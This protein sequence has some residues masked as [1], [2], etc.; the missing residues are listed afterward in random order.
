MKSVFLPPF[1][2][3]FLWMID[4]VGGETPRKDFRGK[5]LKEVDLESVTDRVSVSTVSL[6]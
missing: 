5:L 4:S 2:S 6:Q 3:C 1:L